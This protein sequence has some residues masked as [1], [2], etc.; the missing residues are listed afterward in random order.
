MPVLFREACDGGRGRVAVFLR[1]DMPVGMGRIFAREVLAKR[2]KEATA[3]Q[4]LAAL[5][6]E[7]LESAPAGGIGRIEQLLQDGKL[8]RRDFRII[9]EVFCAAGLHVVPKGL[10]S[11]QVAHLRA[12]QQLGDR[13]HVDI[14]DIQQ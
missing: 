2:E 6:P 14:Q 11:D 5:A 12:V 8:H 7:P 10:G 13:S 4:H 1:P 9:D 3:L